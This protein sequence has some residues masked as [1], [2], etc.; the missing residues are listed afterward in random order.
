MRSV[1]VSHSAADS[2]AAMQ[3]APPAR[4]RE[5]VETLREKQALFST[6]HPVFE[7]KEGGFCEGLA[8]N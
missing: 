6:I 7:K 3:H 1:D 4:G 2:R 5:K 8:E